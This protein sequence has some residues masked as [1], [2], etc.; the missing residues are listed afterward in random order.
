MIRFLL[1]LIICTLAFN[2]IS[3]I[4][5]SLG[6]GMSAKNLLVYM[7]AGWLLLHRGLGPPVRAELRTIQICFMV[8]IAYATITMFIASGIIHYEGYDLRHSALDLKILLIDSFV[9]FMVFFYG[10]R[11][12]AD[13]RALLKMLLFVVSIANLFTIAKAARDHRLWSH[14]RCVT[15]IPLPFPR[16]RSIRR[17]ERNRHYDRL[18]FAGV[19]IPH[20]VRKRIR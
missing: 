4:G 3:G 8:L 19:R 7:G 10:T 13:A 6:A 12:N 18:S 2:D 17:G 11:T 1:F 9:F 15:A 5:L 20:F 16:R 14:D